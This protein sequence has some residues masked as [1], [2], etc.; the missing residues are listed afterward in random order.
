MC[1]RNYTL[2][3]NLST[4]LGIPTNVLAAV[5]VKRPPHDSK[6]IWAFKGHD[7]AHKQRFMIT[8]VRNGRRIFVIQRNT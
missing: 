3:C 4:A 6:L 8:A 7:E 1:A 5:V 2:N